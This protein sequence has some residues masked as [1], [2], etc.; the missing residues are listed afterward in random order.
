MKILT[1][2]VDFWRRISQD[3]SSS[4][5]KSIYDLM[6][7]DFDF[8][9]L[10]E[11]NPFSICG[12]E[13]DVKDGSYFHFQ[14]GNKNIYYHELSG[15]L[16]KES[17]KPPFWGTAI[18]ANEKYKM[19]KKHF[20]NDNGD[21]ESKYF[22]Y[23]ALMCYDFELNNS[24]ITIANFY[25][26]GDASKRDWKVKYEYVDGF[27][28]DISKII[29]NGNNKNI[30]ILAGDFNANNIDCQRIEN[31]GFDEK[32]KHIKNTMVE[33][34]EVYPYHND[35]IFINKNY[36]ELINESDVKR[37]PNGKSPEDIYK[38]F[39]DHYGIECTINI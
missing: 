34:A 11:I 22:G 28:T 13:Y 15:I 38:C 33:V 3:D 4:W 26:K 6:Q 1:W 25:K 7:S 23:E 39:S 5:K 31:I 27:F 18:I 2:N 9:L 32:T 17:S 14:V 10:Q 24:Q 16:S 37:F 30:T 8:I 12:F 21:I 36:S 29:D 19:L 35:C 20:Y